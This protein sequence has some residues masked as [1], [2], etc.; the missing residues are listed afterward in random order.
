M[1]LKFRFVNKADQD[2][3]VIY[4]DGTIG[5]DIWEEWMTGKKSEN[6]I[7]EFR[8]KLA[9]VTT[10]A[11]HVI[12][13]SFG[14]SLRDGISIMDEIYKF[15]GDVETYI[16]GMT[17]SSGS[18][19]P[20]GAKKGKRKMSKNALL[21]I[22]QVMLPVCEWLNQNKA[23]IYL[24]D[25]QKTSDHVAGIY[26][27]RSGKDKQYFIDLMNQANGDGVWLTADEALEHGLIDEIVDYA[28][29]AGEGDNGSEDSVQNIAG[30]ELIH[31]AQSLPPIPEEKLAAL[32]ARDARSRQIQLLMLKRKAS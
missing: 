26:A 21:L 28:H 24:K 12:V 1:N 16:E 7:E 4:I 8:K 19:I 6:T 5:R 25:L 11:V 10:T 31:A 29:D 22:H 14:G 32:S 27:D 18:I 30:M 3:T 9:E 23:D 2:V 17:A 15:Q 13:N 20:Q